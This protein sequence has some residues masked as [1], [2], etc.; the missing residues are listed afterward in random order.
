M[1]QVLFLFGLAAH[2]WMQGSQFDRTKSLSQPACGRLASCNP[3]AASLA[4]RIQACWQEPGTV[5]V[6]QG[7]RDAEHDALLP[8][9]N[10]GPYPSHRIP[11]IKA[12]ARSTA[13]LLLDSTFGELRR[14]RSVPLVTSTWS[15]PKRGQ[16]SHVCCRWLGLSCARPV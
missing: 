15:C 11:R 8:L 4:F 9:A 12:E 3:R 6:N 5:N 1:W 10:R 16:L 13:L 2:F 14:G 7:W